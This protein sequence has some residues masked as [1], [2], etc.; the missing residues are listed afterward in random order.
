MLQKKEQDGTTV[1]EDQ[2]ILECYLHL[3]Q[4]RCREAGREYRKAAQRV[5]LSA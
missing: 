4:Y 1:R 3:M 2:S 5:L